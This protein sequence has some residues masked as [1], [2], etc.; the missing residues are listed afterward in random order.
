MGHKTREAIM[1]FQKEN[2][3][4]ADGIIGNQTKIAMQMAYIGKAN[5]KKG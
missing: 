2:N 4:V 5:K 3:I 1:N